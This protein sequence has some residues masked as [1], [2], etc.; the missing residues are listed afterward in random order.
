MDYAKVFAGIASAKPGSGGFGEYLRA[1]RHTLGLLKYEHKTTQENKEILAAEFVVLD[2]QPAPGAQPHAV[3]EVVSTHWRLSGLNGWKENSELARAQAFVTAVNDLAPEIAALRASDPSGGAAVARVQ[4]AGLEMIGA[5]QPGRGRVVVAVGKPYVPK[6]ERGKAPDP[7][8][9]G[10]IVVDFSSAQPGANALEAIAQRRAQFDAQ[11]GP[12]QLQSQQPAPSYGHAAQAAP[13]GQPPAGHMPQGY[14]PAPGYAQPATQPQGQ[15]P[16]GYAP[17]AGYAPQWAPPAQPPAMAPPPGYGY[18]PGA[19][20]QWGP[21]PA[22]PQAPTAAP[23][24]L[25]PGMR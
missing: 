11:F 22:Q 5:A 18:P 20:P 6:A 12:P 1:G 16:H 8:K 9:A 14:A 15:P 24:M 17:V 21:P 7:T 2:S 4:Q 23:S 3:G 10:F 25:P 13:V 19:Q